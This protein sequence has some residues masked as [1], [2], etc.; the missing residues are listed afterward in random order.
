MECMHNDSLFNVER[1]II[2]CLRDIICN[3]SLL[4]DRS[5]FDLDQMPPCTAKC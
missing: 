4:F 5:A 2:V 1:H 3:T